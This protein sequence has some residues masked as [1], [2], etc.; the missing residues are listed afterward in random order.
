MTWGC[1]VCLAKPIRDP[2]SGRRC[3]RYCATHRAGCRILLI[4]DN[5][6]HQKVG[7]S[8][9]RNSRTGQDGKNQA[10]EITFSL[11]ANTTKSLSISTRIER[12]S[13]SYHPILFA[14]FNH[15]T[16]QAR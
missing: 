14:N 15:L 2:R 10:T 12:L 16:C 4:E 11:S 9:L 13:S 1:D 8:L 5:V 3:K 7:V 6:V